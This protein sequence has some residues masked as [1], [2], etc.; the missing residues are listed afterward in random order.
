MADAR[1]K[2]S[3]QRVHRAWQ[4]L[5]LRGGLLA[6]LV[7]ALV[8]GPRGLEGQLDAELFPLRVVRITG[9][10]R[11]MDRS[12]LERAVAGVAR[13]GFFSVDV[14][15]VRAAAQALPWVETVRVRRVWPDT[16][17]L[18]VEER[19][20]LGHWNDKQLVSLRGDVFQPAPEDPL[21]PDLPWLGG[22]EGSAKTVVDTYRSIQTR[23]D[24]QGMR[25]DRLTLTAR[26]DWSAQLSDGT[27]VLFG[28]E[29]LAARVETFLRVYPL[30]RSAGEGRVKRVDLRY[31][32][33][34]AVLRV[35]TEPAPPGRGDGG[36]AS[37]SAAAPA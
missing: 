12:A 37:G 14:D 33:G 1:G 6:A 2:G 27:L 13:G 34:V 9:E 24:S 35:P 7:G 10:L 29:H 8:L 30:L 4:R 15:R 19:E 26:E 18:S 16:L 32:N 28:T 31:D 5:L 23:L 22:P 17:A 20:P 11:H 21:A 25:I 36:P 3:E